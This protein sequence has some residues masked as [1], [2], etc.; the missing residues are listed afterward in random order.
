M[1]TPGKPRAGLTA[2][3]PSARRAR[4]WSAAAIVVTAVL[5]ATVLL[6]SSGAVETFD[7]GWRRPPSAS[8]VAPTWYLPCAR[9]APRSD[10]ELLAACARVRGRVLAVRHEGAERETHLAVLAEFQLL[11]VKLG[12]GRRAP[13]LG[14][15][16]VAVGPLVRAR[17]GLREVDAIEARSP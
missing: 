15:T 10:R 1:V 7:A 9:R 16:I 4:V 11:L 6:A 17:N 8:R 13:D 2:T 12:A 5:A 14:E 3:P